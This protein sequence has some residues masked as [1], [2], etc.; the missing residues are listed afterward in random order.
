VTT[1]TQ[2]AVVDTATNTVI[3]QLPLGS[4]PYPIAL[5]SDGTKAY[6]G[7]L[8]P[9]CYTLLGVDTA[10]GSVVQRVGC[11]ACAAL[12]ST[13][14]LV[15][16]VALTPDGQRAYVS[17]IFDL[18][19]VVFA[20]D[21]HTGATVATI[22]F[23][24]QPRGLAVTP[25]G[26]R[27]YVALNDETSIS[28]GNGVGVIDTATNILTSV[29]PLSEAGGFADAVAMRPDG[30]AVYV[31]FSA[32][33]G[34]SVVAI[35]T[36]QSL[37]PG[38]NPVISRTQLDRQA[39]GLAFTPDGRFAYAAGGNEVSIIDTSTSSLVYRVPVPDEATDVAIGT[40]P[41]GCVAPLNPVP[42]ATLTSTA[43]ATATWT[44]TPTPS[45]TN[46]STPQPATATE[47]PT[48]TGTPPPTLTPTPSALP[49]STVTRTPLPSATPTSPA[50]TTP[51]PTAPPTF[52]PTA[53]PSGGGG[54]SIA[55]SAPRAFPTAWGLLIV[56]GTLLW[57]R[58]R[59][60]TAGAPRRAGDR[61]L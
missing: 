32:P 49:T 21:L 56:P 37:S 29:I 8:Q 55:P 14:S 40:V 46:T 36:T 19:G 24:D 18:T 48:A 35:D 31:T 58:K 50:T 26:R 5:S 51:T 3:N 59:Q 12:P 23:E 10:T 33:S 13:E 7:L 44:V 25:D 15:A 38:Q 41:Y 2:L 39:S 27:V 47:T 52:T 54:C 11:A 42:T 34:N 4:E 30:R 61:T 16:S 1:D 60:A 45:V 9:S 22:A 43:S 57:L 53:R 28:H 6:V 17:Q 20:V